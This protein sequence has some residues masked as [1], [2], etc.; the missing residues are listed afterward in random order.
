MQET[1]TFG[2]KVALISALVVALLF[3]VVFAVR[4]WW[5]AYTSEEE[6]LPSTPPTEDSQLLSETD[7]DN[8]GLSDDI[9][10]I[11][12]S[13]P[14]VADT[15]GDGTNDGEEVTLLRNPTVPGPN[16][17]IFPDEEE[18]IELSGEFTNKYLA[19]V[20]VDATR[21]EVLSSER[22]EAF[23]EQE[24]QAFTSD[25]YPFT[26]ETVADSGAEAIEGYLEQISSAHNDELVV[27]TSDDISEAFL[28]SYSQGDSAA[29]DGIVSDLESNL[30]ILQSVPAPEEASAL[31][32]QLVAAS[33]AL[34][35]NTRLLPEMGNDFVGG[36]IGAKNI[37]ELGLEFQSIADQI[38]AL[39]EKYGLE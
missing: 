32:A 9:E 24:R 38:A 23:V 31:H 7:S 1:N 17:A 10:L 11:Y 35:E 28:T 18:S 20:P 8:D 30:A 14:Q 13:D 6:P 2:L 34:L 27:V 21:E 39:E 16:D 15:D 37:E 19:L 12:R 25:K 5:N 3:G 4:L 29:I 33:Q 22:I 36:L 26:P